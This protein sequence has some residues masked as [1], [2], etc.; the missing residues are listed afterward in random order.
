MPYIGD[1]PSAITHTLWALPPVEVS[2]WH[3]HA[4]AHILWVRVFCGCVSSVFC[5]LVLG[6]VYGIA[7]CLRMWWGDVYS[8]QCAGCV[9]MYLEGGKLFR[10]RTLNR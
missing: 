4:R 3:T 6:L 1:V 8:T 10:A 7:G 5:G 9:C 2:F